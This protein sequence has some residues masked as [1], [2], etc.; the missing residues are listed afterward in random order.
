MEPSENGHSVGQMVVTLTHKDNIIVP[1]VKETP[2]EDPSLKHT[3]EPVSTLT[4]KLPDSMPKSPPDNGNTKLVL[5]SELKS[6][7][8]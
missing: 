1:S 5:P 8:T 4:S 3:S 2:S 6:E 7:I